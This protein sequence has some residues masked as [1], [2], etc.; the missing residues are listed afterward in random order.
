M[1]IYLSHNFIFIFYLFNLLTNIKCAFGNN[2]SNNCEF[3]KEIPY[4]H[5]T[6]V[7]DNLYSNSN[8]CLNKNYNYNLPGSS[9]QNHDGQNVVELS[10]E[11]FQN[12][13]INDNETFIKYVN[14]IHKK[15]A[16]F[17]NSLDQVNDMRHKDNTFFTFK[18][19]DKR[20]ESKDFI[21]E[22]NYL[23]ECFE[24]LKR[25]P[26]YGNLSYNGNV[27]IEMLNRDL[28]KIKS[29]LK[30]KNKKTNKSKIKNETYKFYD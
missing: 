11:L 24:N 22:F 7:N 23:K 18:E 21:I 2:L 19:S 12:Q 6:N 26:W 28:D 9:A 3:Y 15:I 16:T 25:Q 14:C 5:E 13:K 1:F 29:K 4:S 30:T 27:R 17:S 20:E 10:N 8:D